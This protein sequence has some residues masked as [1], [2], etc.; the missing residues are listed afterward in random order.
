MSHLRL[1]PAALVMGAMA[2]CGGGNAATSSTAPA[3]PATTSRPAPTAA[4]ASKSNAAATVDPCTLL[5][6][7]EVASAMAV[8]MGQGTPKHVVDNQ[9]CEWTSTDGQ[10]RQA[11]VRIYDEAGKARFDRLCG[12]SGQPAP[13]VG[14]D[15]SCYLG[16][17]VNEYVVLKGSTV[18]AV[19]AVENNLRPMKKQAQALVAVVLTKV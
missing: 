8:P 13:E 18:F 10:N 7:D 16:G 19:G 1:L 2:A 12:T 6:V 4:S 17:G 15:S 14:G 11:V 5:T 3:G 9:S